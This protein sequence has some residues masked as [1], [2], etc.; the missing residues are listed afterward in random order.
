MII[1]EF[2]RKQHKM[3]EEIMNAGFIAC[4]IKLTCPELTPRAKWLTLK[5]KGVKL[6]KMYKNSK[7]TFNVFTYFHL[8][9]YKW[10][11]R[12]NEMEAK[13]M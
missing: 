6:L 5:H 7:Y 4:A 9:R 8:Y 10:I 3:C 13:S 1:P 2:Q 12:R 11:K